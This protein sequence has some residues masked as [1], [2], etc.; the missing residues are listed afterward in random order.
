MLEMRMLIEK[1]QYL[2]G[3][4]KFFKGITYDYRFEVKLVSAGKAKRK[5][6]KAAKKK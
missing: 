5:K 6:G 3:N 1:G 4:R 2:E